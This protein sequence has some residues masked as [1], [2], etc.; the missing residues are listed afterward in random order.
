MLGNKTRCSTDL[1]NVQIL[2]LYIIFYDIGLNKAYKSGL[3]PLLFFLLPYSEHP[4]GRCLVLPISQKLHPF[5]GSYEETCK[6]IGK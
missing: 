6:M 2:Y 5:L 1:L 3:L 4:C